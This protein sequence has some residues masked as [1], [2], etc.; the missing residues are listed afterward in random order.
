MRCL[1]F[2]LP[3]VI[4][5]IG[6]DRS[7]P[8]APPAKD[9]DKTGPVKVRLVH[10]TVRT[11]EYPA[12]VKPLFETPIHARVP[13]FV[14]SI[15]VD[16]DDVVKGP[17]EGAKP[18]EPDDKEES[19]AYGGQV[20]AR[21]RVPE[22][23]E[24]VE[25]KRRVVAQCDAEIKEAEEAYKAAVA[26]VAEVKA[27]TDRVEADLK[28]WQ[29]QLAGL[30][31]G[32]SVGKQ[33]LDEVR[34]QVE[35]SKA[36]KVEQAAKVTAS[37]AAQK[38]YEA[39]IPAAKAKRDAAEADRRKS[40]AMLRYSVVRAPF[41]GVVSRRLADVG[42]Y[43]Q[44]GAAGP[45]GEP[46]FVITRTDRVRVIA[47]VP[48]ADVGQIQNKAKVW[49]RVPALE[50]GSYEGEVS[51][52]S[53]ALDARS[54][55][56]EVAIDIDNPG[57]RLRTEMYAIA[58]IAVSPR[59]LTLP[60][61]AVVIQGDQAYAYRVVDGRAVRTPVKVGK[62]AAGLIDVADVNEKDEFVGD[63]AASLSDGASVVVEGK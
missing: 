53:W 29:A 22:L 10:P 18:P 58:N 40:L 15:D 54:R 59:A 33:E 21:L 57:K 38:K 39:V 11:I 17:V 19:V 52:T 25:L 30:E 35:A 43:R 46:L 13:G 31:S 6:C 7:P 8:A 49:L 9:A 55:T 14:Q 2:T 41:N 12:R 20:L 1:H 45:R 28:R 26:R 47:E 63:N 61:P 5:T 56:L 32:V 24:E 27:G 4:V 50:N 16:I 34:F 23:D 48:E 44:P 36:A 42:H 37:E 60:A 62:T 3:I 51:R